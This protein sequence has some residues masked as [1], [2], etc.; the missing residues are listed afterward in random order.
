VIA[1]LDTATLAPRRPLRERI[2]TKVAG[3]LP[4][5]F[6]RRG[7]G[8]EF[9]SLPATT[10]LA[11]QVA[12]YAEPLT[13]GWTKAAAVGATLV[14]AGGV[15]SAGSKVSSQPLNSLPEG[16]SSG[17]L[18]AP[19]ATA[20]ASR[21]ERRGPLLRRTAGVAT[22]RHKPRASVG[23]PSAGGGTTSPAGSAPAAAVTPTTPDDP[24]QTPSYDGASKPSHSPG[25]LPGGGSSG[26]DAG[27][28]QPSGDGPSAALPIKTPTLNAVQDVAQSVDPSVGAVVGEAR[29][30]IEQA[31]SLGG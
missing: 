29:D 25:Q 16:R 7:R 12:M 13:A 23:T 18:V 10:H 15:A 19:A 14:L 2:A 6:L 21:A 30:V 24:A 22:P 27:S 8:D 17:P 11:G 26:G 3:L 28:P 4:F 9:A 20:P 31:T 1:G 5:P